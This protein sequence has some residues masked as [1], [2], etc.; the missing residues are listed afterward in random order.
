MIDE[1]S[2]REALESAA[3]AHIL[4]T[5]FTLWGLIRGLRWQRGGSTRDS[6][7]LWLEQ[8]GAETVIERWP[9]GWS[10]ARWWRAG[11]LRANRPPVVRSWNCWCLTWR[12]CS[13]GSRLLGS[14]S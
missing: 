5:F 1:A 10:W 9:C 11:E 8:G 13:Y 6:Q 7:P 3:W 12:T 2:R 14:G 4:R